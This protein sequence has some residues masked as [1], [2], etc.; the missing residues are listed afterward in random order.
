MVCLLARHLW[1]CS[2]RYDPF[3][4]KTIQILNALS[5]ERQQGHAYLIRAKCAWHDC[6]SSERTGEHLLRKWPDSRTIVVQYWFGYPRIYLHWMSN[7]ACQ[8]TVCIFTENLEHYIDV[9]CASWTRRTANSSACRVKWT[10]SCNEGH[11]PPCIVWCYL[12]ARRCV[13]AWR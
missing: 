6:Y 5:R 13:L 7:L 12:S 2:V 1:L 11:H 9:S 10:K 3:R 4:L 8:N